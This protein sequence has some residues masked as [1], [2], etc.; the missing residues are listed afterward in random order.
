MEAHTQWKHI[1]NWV[2]THGKNMVPWCP[3]IGPLAAKALG[4][5]HSH[6]Q[7]WEH[8]LTT[9]QTKSG[10]TNTMRLLDLWKREMKI[11]IFGSK[12]PCSSCSSFLEWLFL[13]C[14]KNR[15]DVLR[16]NFVV[17]GP[18]EIFQLWCARSSNVFFLSFPVE[19][20]FCSSIY[21]FFQFQFSISFSYNL[22]QKRSA[23]SPNLWINAGIGSLSWHV[24]DLVAFFSQCDDVLY[25][26]WLQT[27]FW[28][29]WTIQPDIF[30]LIY[31]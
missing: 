25:V 19:I 21:T 18:A 30:H 10:E 9:N 26:L 16:G 27:C 11:W 2:K 12:A 6:T 23:I 22:S 31:S 14:L 13:F 24:L 1:G 7:L 5:R 17:P 3:P 20:I 29:A 4:L 15:T 28:F 8:C